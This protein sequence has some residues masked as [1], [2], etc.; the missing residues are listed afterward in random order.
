MHSP[1]NGYKFT[2]PLTKIYISVVHIVGIQLIRD[3]SLLLFWQIILP[4]S[5][6]EDTLSVAVVEDVGIDLMKE[7]DVQFWKVV[8]FLFVYLILENLMRTLLP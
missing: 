3:L 8:L 1:C 5:L 4:V 7:L 2:D 6:R